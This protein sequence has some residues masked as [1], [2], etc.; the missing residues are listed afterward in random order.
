MDKSE[1]IKS[2]ADYDSRREVS[3]V[4]IKD[5]E[6]RRLLFSLVEAETN[7]KSLDIRMDDIV[8]ISKHN[9]IFDKSEILRNSMDAIS[10][11]GEWDS[12]L[13]QPVVPSII[14]FLDYEYDSINEKAADIIVHAV[15]KDNIELISRAIP[16][17]LNLLD[18]YEYSIE[19]QETSNSDSVVNAEQALY[20]I[21]SLS[22]E[23]LKGAVPV[24]IKY[25]D[26][27]YPGMISG[28]LKNISEQNGELISPIVSDI[29][30]RIDKKEHILIIGNVAKND[31]EII[32]PAIKPLIKQLDNPGFQETSAYVLGIIAQKKV[33]FVE[34][35]I[36]KLID[37]LSSGDKWVRIY[38]A[39]SL[40]IVSQQNE[41]FVDDSTIE[42]LDD[43]IDGVNLFDEITHLSPIHEHNTREYYNLAS[44][45]IKENPG[46]PDALKAFG[47]MVIDTYNGY[48]FDLSRKSYLNSFEKGIEY[49][50]KSAEIKPS[51]ETYYHIG[52]AYN[53]S[54]MHIGA[55]HKS[56]KD[57]SLKNSIYYYEKAHE[58]NPD[59]IESPLRIA[60]NNNM[61]GNYEKAISLAEELYKRAPDDCEV[62][63]KLANFYVEAAKRLNEEKKYYD[64]YNFLLK[65]NNIEDSYPGT[66]EDI[67]QMLGDENLKSK[68]KSQL[69]NLN[70]TN[71]THAK[72]RSEKFSEAGELAY[73]KCIENAPELASDAQTEL[74][75]ILA[76]DTLISKTNQE[77]E[78]AKGGK[79]KTGLLGKLG[80]AVSSVAKQGKSKVE[81]Y[82]LERKKN[83]A[84]TDFGEA[85]WESHKSGDD[86]L[87]ELSDIWQAIEDIEHQ[88]RTN[89]EEID[90][91]NELL[92]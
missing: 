48:E 70:S 77:M 46:D 61:L 19:G 28:I 66:R 27:D 69:N 51:F 79:K 91:L 58:L 85:L 80:D 6:V 47:E 82:N 90:N 18:Y 12:Q 30:E 15:N 63:C 31:V 52:Q 29:I 4:V 16:K 62:S 78:K 68:L 73:S 5:E 24:L 50:K 75:D 43:I 44:K 53:L 21:S 1:L 33:E 49:F 26:R 64:A 25:V 56:N 22:P 60:I 76:I 89:E 10:D 14:H 13:V 84:I 55:E 57:E 71:K 8:T 67:D 41:T 35:A 7:N 2:L 38:A 74:D 87:Q 83:S 11:L 88:I 81:L 45:S 92:G 59:D 17:L 54:W 20:F 65:A 36:P 23:S 39:R 32:R 72:E 42:K 34:P 40:K 37:L 3:K 86:A 9:K